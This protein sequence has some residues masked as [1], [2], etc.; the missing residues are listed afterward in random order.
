M[1]VKFK[2]CK[3]DCKNQYI[4][5]YE[6]IHGKAVLREEHKLLSNCNEFEKY[7]DYVVILTA[8]NGDCNLFHLGKE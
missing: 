2:D 6:I 7:D 8:F 4:T 5:I 3:L 1:I